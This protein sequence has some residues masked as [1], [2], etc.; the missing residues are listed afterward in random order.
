[1]GHFGPS[2]NPEDFRPFLAAVLA[3]IAAKAG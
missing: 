3:K 1:M 2:E